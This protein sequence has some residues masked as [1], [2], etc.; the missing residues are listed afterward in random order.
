MAR[1]L[2]P[3]SDLASGER[4]LERLLARPRDPRLEVELLAIVDPLIPGRIPM[5]VSR[6]RAEAQ[7]SRAARRW[8]ERLEPKL[9]DARI[10]YRSHIAMGARGAVL[11]Q[12]GTRPD[13][14]EVLLGTGV[15]DPL[16]RWR[17]RFVAHAMQRPVVS[18]T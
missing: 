9:E 18:I 11:R 1:V 14:D 16:G 4:A 12:A 5:I 2:I 7:A 8:L 17:R 3:F 13:I 6:E 15:R 10:A